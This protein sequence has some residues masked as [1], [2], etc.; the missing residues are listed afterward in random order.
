MEWDTAAGQS[1]VN[2][3]G[4]EVVSMYDRQ[5]LRYNKQDLKN[6]PFLCRGRSSDTEDYSLNLN[7]DALHS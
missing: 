4:G 1:I 6:D 3:S 2:E 5:P 7:L